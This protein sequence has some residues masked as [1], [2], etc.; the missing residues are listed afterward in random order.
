[1]HYC[2]LRSASEDN[3]SSLRD[4]KQSSAVCTSGL[5]ASYLAVRCHLLKE[6]LSNSKFLETL[7]PLGSHIWKRTK[8]LGH[9]CYQMIKKTNQ[10]KKKPY[11]LPCKMVIFLPIKSKCEVVIVIL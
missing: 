3:A 6:I 2:A 10:N 9:Y 1:M 5:C 11:F 8:L 4:W 7:W